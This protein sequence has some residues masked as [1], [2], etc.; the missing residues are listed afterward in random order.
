MFIEGD[1]M[2]IVKNINNNYAIAED[3][4]GKS[5]IVSGK[6]IGFGEVPREVKDLTVINRSY[7]DVDVSC[8]SLINDIPENIIQI[9]S[10]AI[11]KARE[12]I[13]SPIG[14]NVIFTL[15][16]HINFSIERHKKGMN[17]KLPIFRDVQHLLENEMKVGKYALMLIRKELDIWLP[18]HEAAC[19]A[20]HVFNAEE[21]NIN[22]INNDF[23][24][25]NI[26]TIIE[27]EY[28]I[29]ID[30]NGFHYSRFVSHMHYL[31]RRKE[32]RLS[33]ESGDDAL[34]YSVKE[35][36][37]KVFSCMDDVSFLIERRLK[38]KLSNKE[39]LYLMLH[40]ERLCSGE[41]CN[42]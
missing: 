18:P 23:L 15:A 41:D 17:I 24:I 10:K 30:R 40:I 9:S 35:A 32:S 25:D 14:S 33:V 27:E 39:K 16:D 12:L 11:D 37:P 28:G 1:V 5:L 20:L 19:I 22:E 21:N 26:I 34:F 6:G 31:I 29:C 13:D 7:Y 4:A 3:S 2:L 42:H 38:L 8:I 36:Y